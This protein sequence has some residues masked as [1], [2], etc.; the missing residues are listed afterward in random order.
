MY[1]PELRLRLISKMP[2]FATP[3]FDAYPA[4]RKLRGLSIGGQ[5]AIT[6]MKAVPVIA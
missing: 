1:L 5:T 4:R 3:G 2:E 6:S